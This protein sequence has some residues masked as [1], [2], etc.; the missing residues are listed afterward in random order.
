MGQGKVGNRHRDVRRF[1]HLENTFYGQSCKEA[2]GIYTSL[3]HLRK[4]LGVKSID[5]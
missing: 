3:L 4:L 5:S 2:M 1:D